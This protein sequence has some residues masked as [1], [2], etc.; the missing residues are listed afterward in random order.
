ML[1]KLF[2]LKLNVS[3]RKYGYKE[4]ANFAIN[5]WNQGWKKWY[6]SQND[7]MHSTHNKGKSVV[8]ETFIRTLQIFL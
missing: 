6:I 7:V 4:A 3:Q 8:A 5:Q 2:K 1:S